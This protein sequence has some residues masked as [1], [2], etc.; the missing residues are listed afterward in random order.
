MDRTYHEPAPAP[1]RA[2][3]LAGVLRRMP[4]GKYRAMNSPVEPAVLNFAR[5]IPQLDGLRGVAILLV[6]VG[7][8]VNEWAPLPVLWR[9]SELANLGVVV[10]F[11]LSGFLITT[12]I[13]EEKHTSGTVGLRRFYF[14]RF[15][16]LGPALAVFLAVTAL[17][18]L[19]GYIN[20]IGAQRVSFLHFLFAE[21]LWK[22]YGCR[23]LMV[24]LARRA[25][26]RDLAAPG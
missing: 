19:R 5:H 14:R 17:L 16:R 13:L 8:L 21:F 25:V 23:P 3:V 7:H 15:L 2:N 12:L 1:L 11:V 22:Q 4:A 6:V 18:S 26:L 24:A 20:K 10:F 9:F